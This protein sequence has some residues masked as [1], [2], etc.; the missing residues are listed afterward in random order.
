MIHEYAAHGLGGGSHEGAAR[1]KGLL[2]AELQVG[3]MNQGGGIERV[4]GGFK[5]K[6]GCGEPTQFVVKQRQQPRGGLRITLLDGFEYL[7]D[8]AHEAE[9]TRAER[10]SQVGGKFASARLTYSRL[11]PA[12]FSAAICL[13]KNLNLARGSFRLG[14]SVIGNDAIYQSAISR[15]QS[16]PG[17]KEG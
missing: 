9:D 8:L 1:R 5:C 13:E 6:F 15:I 14:F 11:L 12:P 4:P 16:R 2:A 17:G 3:F 10:G 7:W